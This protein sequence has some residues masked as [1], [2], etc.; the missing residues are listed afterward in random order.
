MAA[1]VASL[2]R[3]PTSAP[4]RSRAS[5]RGRLRPPPAPA[6]ADSPPRPVSFNAA[7]E[8][9]RRVPVSSAATLEVSVDEPGSVELPG[10]GLDRQRRPAHAR[11]L[12]RSSPR[13]PGATSSCSPPRTGTRRGRRAPWSSTHRAAGDDRG[14]RLLRW[15]SSSS[16]LRA[17]DVRLLHRRPPAPRRARLPVRMG[18]REAPPGRPGGGRD[19]LPP[20]P[21]ARPHHRAA[22]APVPRGRP[23]RRGQALAR[24][25]RARVPAALPQRRSS[26]GPT[27]ATLVAELPEQGAGAL[28]CVERDPEACHR[29]LIADRI[30]AE[31]GVPVTHLGPA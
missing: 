13:A 3:P 26:T 21:R 1:L 6:P 29:S 15:T 8:E 30:A 2:S 14:L 4:A 10:L 24:R 19:R 16:T 23:A 31:Y 17:A 20:P 18:Q 25:A 5:S 12:R 22:P 28:F 27:S 9:R 7:S 11:P